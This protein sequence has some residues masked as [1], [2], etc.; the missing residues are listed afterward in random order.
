MKV[1]AVSVLMIEGLQ[2]PLMPLSEV[3]GKAGAAA[4]AHIPAMA[5]NV[6]VVLVP[7]VTVRLTVPAHKPAAGVKT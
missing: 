7:T 5:A 6:G 4:P 1:P 2:V 3:V